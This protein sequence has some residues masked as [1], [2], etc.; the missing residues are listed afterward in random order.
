VSGLGGSP[1]VA[2][3]LPAYGLLRLHGTVLIM[4]TFCMWHRVTSSLLMMHSVCVRHQAL[5]VC[6]LS[7]FRQTMWSLDDQGGRPTMD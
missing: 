4:H 2:T 5:L 3:L 6:I 1:H 7:G